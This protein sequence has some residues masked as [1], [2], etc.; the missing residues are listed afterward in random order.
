MNKKLDVVN[1]LRGFS[2]FTIVLMH[3]VQS[4][5]I[6]NLLMK[7]VSF[8]GAGVHVFILCSGFG[9]YLS[10]LNKPVTYP[11]FLK[12]RFLKIYLPYAIIIIISALLPFYNTSPNKWIQLS[13]HLLLYK[14]FVE[15]WECSYGIQFWF[16]STIIQFYIAWPLILRIFKRGGVIL[17]LIISLGWSTLVGV[18]DLSDER[19]WN[20]FFLQ[21]LWE[22]VLGMQLASYYKTYPENF[23]M[24]PTCKILLPIC[25][26]GVIL[27]GVTGVLGG[28]WKSYN[29]IPSL[30]G[31]M[32][33][34]LILYKVN[35]RFINKFFVY[36]N[37]ISYEWYLVHIL[38]FTCSNL[39]LD[40][41]FH[42]PSLIRAT[43]AFILSF[44]VA[45][46]YHKILKAL[47]LV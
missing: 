3:L 11:Q 7:A 43:V 24:I 15:R 41:F 9:L 31:Y 39:L 46:G 18:S 27:V 29:D 44:L 6:G 20:S 21:Y 40:T 13:S 2:I 8:G 10:Y 28:I 38:V 5:P 25:L 4:Y 47:K 32:G 12:R 37:K 45:I 14:M 16:V 1:F 36:T 35:I 30:F 19:V 26:L 34:A 42:V 22:F 33:M 23:K 17:A